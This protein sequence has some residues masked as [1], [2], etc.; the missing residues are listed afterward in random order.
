MICISLKKN[1]YKE[2]VQSIEGYLE[3]ERRIFDIMITYK[4]SLIN[5]WKVKSKLL[6]DSI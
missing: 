2:S 6:E 5:D 3:G 4:E 1:N